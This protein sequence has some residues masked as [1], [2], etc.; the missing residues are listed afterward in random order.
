MK[1]TTFRPQKKSSTIQTRM[2]QY[3]KDTLDAAAALRGCSRAEYI[4]DVAAK[5]ALKDLGFKTMHE[6]RE[7]KAKGEI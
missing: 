7:A 5:A 1:T 6:F 2:P 4:R 3:M